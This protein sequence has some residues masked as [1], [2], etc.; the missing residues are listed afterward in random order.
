[1]KIII[2]HSNLVVGGGIQVGSSFLNDLR[3]IRA[4][5]EFHI[6]QSFYSKESIDKSL[7]PE[8]FIFYDLGLTEIQSIRNRGNRVKNIEKKV[9]PD[10]I[11]VTFGPSYYKSKCKKIVGFAIPYI[12]YPE[13]PYFETLS[14]LELLKF[15]LLS[16]FKIRSFNKN[17]NALIFESE[18]AE[19]VFRKFI[20]DKI[21]TFTVHNTLNEIFHESSRWKNLD[22]EIPNSTNILCLSANYS[23]KNLVIIP[24]VINVLK[25]KYNF[26]DFN[27]IVTLEENNLEVS[28]EDKKNICFINKVPLNQIP[29][30][31]KKSTI[32][33][34]PTLLEVFSTTY[35]EAMFMEIPIVASDMPFSRDICSDAAIYCDPLKDEDYADAIYKLVVDK[36]LYNDM[37]LKGKNNLKR[38]GTSLDRTYQYLNIIEHI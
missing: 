11:F 15:K 23:H 21:K 25:E 2:D 24:K 1:M 9:D 29:D 12:I 17:S 20:N 34:M 35:L 18:N 19:N 3:K 22:K 16:F 5:H 36:K 10:V 33:F 7:F 13:S 8:N 38:F 28:Q 37:L 6:I 27:F 31:Y 32:L 4:A 30:L 26:Y 14:F